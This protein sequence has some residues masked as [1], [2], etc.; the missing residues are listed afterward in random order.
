[1][2]NQNEKLV[3]VLNAEIVTREGIGKLVMIKPGNML[4]QDYKVQFP[5]GSS[6]WYKLD[7]LQKAYRLSQN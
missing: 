4:K 7:D 5:N 3:P 2:K 1:M 6:K